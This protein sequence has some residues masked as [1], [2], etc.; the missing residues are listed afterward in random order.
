VA[1]GSMPLALTWHL[2]H[3]SMPLVATAGSMPQQVQCHSRWVC[4]SI[5]EHGPLA[6]HM[7]EAVVS[8][9]RPGATL[10]LPMQCQWQHSRTASRVLCQRARL[11]ATGS[12]CEASVLQAIAA[13]CTQCLHVFG[14]FTLG[15]PSACSQ[16]TCARAGCAG[17]LTVCTCYGCGSGRSCCRALGL[18][19]CFLAPAL[20]SQCLLGCW[21][22]QLVFVAAVSWCL[23][24]AMVA[25]STQIDHNPASF[26]HLH[27]TCQQAL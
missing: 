24:L 6:W 22:C 18:Q 19:C 5:I 20:T 2:P 16:V 17:L 27:S 10:A 12:P 4:S 11:P 25:F 14:W 8:S 3:G 15:F 1:A 26:I 7:L 13:G 23:W 9:A 21:L